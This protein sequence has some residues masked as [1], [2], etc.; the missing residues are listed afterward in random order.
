MI[1]LTIAR[2]PSP[3]TVVSSVL[4]FGTGALDI[5]RC[6]IGDFHNTTPSGADRLNQRLHV[7]GYRPGTYPTKTTCAPNSPQGRW[8]A[9][10][11]LGDYEGVV[12]GFPYTTSGRLE[13]HHAPLR[14]KGGGSVLRNV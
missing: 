4:G 10:V 9:N 14:L 3:G 8:P 6:R 7:L 13:P 1:I 11:I 2:K 5:D 12:E